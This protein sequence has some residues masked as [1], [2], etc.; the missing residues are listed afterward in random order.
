MLGVLGVLGKPVEDPHRGLNVAL[1][2]LNYP[3]PD[4]FTIFDSLTQL[5]YSAGVYIIK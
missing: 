1:L 3:E 5:E 2:V 4:R